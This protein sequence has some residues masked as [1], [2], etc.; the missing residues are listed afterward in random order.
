MQPRIRRTGMRP[1]AL[2]VLAVLAVLTLVAPCGTVAAQEFD[3]RETLR[4]QSVEFRKDVIQVADAVYVAVGYSA[5]N[6]T[7][8]Q[9]DSGAIIVDTGSDP[10]AAREVRAAFAGSS[11]PVS[12]G[13]RDEQ[14]GPLE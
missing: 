4:A 3:G 13:S 1:A 5:S 10:V 6:V 9:G 14:P 7:L 11:T 8:I 2:A 12:R